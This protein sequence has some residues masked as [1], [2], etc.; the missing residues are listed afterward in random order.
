[1]SSLLNRSSGGTM[2]VAIGAVTDAVVSLVNVWSVVVLTM[3]GSS[4]VGFAW[5]RRHS[6][7]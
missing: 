4:K 6:L 1:M 5:K 2:S 3:V 7:A